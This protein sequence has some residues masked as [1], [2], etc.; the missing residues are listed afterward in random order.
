ML[1][2]LIEHILIQKIIYQNLKLIQVKL[3]KINFVFQKKK[4]QEVKVN[5]QI[6]NMRINKIQTILNYKKI[7]QVK[8]KVQRK[9]RMI[10]KMIMDQMNLKKKI[11]KNNKKNSSKNNSK[12]K[13][14]NLIKNKNEYN[15]ILFDI[16]I[17][18][19]K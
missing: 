19:R 16:L 10:I 13:S 12:M 7:N 6:V 1:N 3:K 11:I 15:Q 4:L 17:I 2:F 9:Q 8:N 18:I 14:T 5:L